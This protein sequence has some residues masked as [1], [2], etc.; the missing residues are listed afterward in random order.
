MEPECSLPHP[1]VSTTWPYPEPDQSSPCPPFYFLKVHLNIMLSSMRGSPKWSLSLRFPHQNP[2]YTSPLPPY[3][4]HAPPISFF[5]TWSP[6]HIWWAVQIINLLIIKF[7]PFSCYLVPFRPKY[8]PQH[9]ILKHPQPT[10]LPQ[11]EL[12]NFI[13]WL[14]TFSQFLYLCV[15]PRVL[16]RLFIALSVN[17]FL[18][19]S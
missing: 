7:V 19:S 15:F 9:P 13:I 10:F 11:C 8:S 1:Q 3:A 14:V 4:L 16:L 18:D 6:E 2:V 17:R 5:S 12:S